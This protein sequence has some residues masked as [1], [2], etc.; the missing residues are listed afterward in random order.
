LDREVWIQRIADLQE[1]SCIPIDFSDRNEK[2]LAALFANRYPKR[3]EKSVTLRA[4]I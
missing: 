3:A 2:A 1:S 4:R